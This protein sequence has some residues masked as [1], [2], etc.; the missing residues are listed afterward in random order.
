MCDWYC[1]LK[2]AD[3]YFRNHN[4]AL[5]EL[6]IKNVRYLLEN[7]LSHYFTYFLKKI[8]NFTKADFLK[9]R[10]FKVFYKDSQTILYIKWRCM[11]YG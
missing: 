6:T 5:L 9:N 2:W 10:L 11:K 7:D 1:I 3:Q 8:T 4:Y